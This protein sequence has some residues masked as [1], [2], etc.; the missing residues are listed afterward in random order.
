MPKTRELQLWSRVSFVVCVGS[1]ASV[2]V[3]KARTRRM[4]WAG[5]PVEPKVSTKYILFADNRGMRI[6]PLRDVLSANELQTCLTYMND[7]RYVSALR[8]VVVKS[9]GVASYG[10]YADGLEELVGLCLDKGGYLPWSALRR[11]SVASGSAS[12]PPRAAPSR[13]LSSALSR[14]S[15]GDSVDS[16]WHADD[17]QAGVS[18]WLHSFADKYF[19]RLQ[20]VA[21]Q[22]A[23][24]TIAEA[25]RCFH[26]IA[27]NFAQ[28]PEAAREAYSS[29]G[30]SAKL[31][32]KMLGRG[33]SGG[34]S[35]EWE[36]VPADFLKAHLAGML[37][38]GA[39]SGG[40]V[41][42]SLFDERLQ[43]MLTHMDEDADGSISLVS[44]SII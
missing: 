44:F 1:M 40:G 38:Q 43:E 5:R 8:P 16:L 33:V 28:Q 42:D 10:H 18:P 36:Q 30:G 9:A 25:T 24:E 37:Q 20:G 22:P 39:R 35:G 29:Q 14:G 6:R 32:S 11:F 13:S 15:R 4:S 23:A 34:G 2:S 26:L 31:V 21:F 17:E 3:Q 7:N 41:G 12:P 27:A 19:R